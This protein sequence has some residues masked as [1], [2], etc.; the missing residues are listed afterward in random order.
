MQAIIP[1]ADMKVTRRAIQPANPREK[2]KRPLSLVIKT[3]VEENSKQ[4]MFPSCSSRIG[5]KVPKHLHQRIRQ[6][7]QIDVEFSL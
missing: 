4:Q 1:A 2:T 5:D 7:V 6:R 3:A